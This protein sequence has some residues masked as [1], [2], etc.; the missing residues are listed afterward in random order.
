MRADLTRA[1]DALTLARVLAQNALGSMAKDLKSKAAKRKGI[2][3]ECT[4]TAAELT[5]FIEKARH[6][7]VNN[8]DIARF[9]KVRCV[10]RCSH[11]PSD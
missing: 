7:E 8:A 4:V 3:D 6:G 9:A 11:A 1:C 5:S 2:D 10:A